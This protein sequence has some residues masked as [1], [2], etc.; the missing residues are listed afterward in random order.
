MGT[1]LRNPE[2]GKTLRIMLAVS[3]AAAVAAGFFSIPAGIITAAACLLLI[4]IYLHATRQRYERFAQLSY[5]MDQILHGKHDVHI[6]DYREGELSLI[7]DE[8]LKMTTALTEQ[9]ERLAEDKKYLSDSMADISHQLRTP[10]TSSQLIITLLRDPDISRARRRELLQELESLHAH[11]GWLVE[12]LLKISKMDAGTAYFKQD[13]IAVSEL[14]EEAAEP[15]LVPME[16]RNISFKT[17]ISKTAEFTGDLSWSKEAIANI[18][19]NCMEHVSDG[20]EIFIRSESNALY[21]EIQIEDSGRGF[22]P[23]DLPHIFERFYKGKNSSSG[24]VGIGL[25][26]ARMIVAEQNGTIKAENRTEG[27]ARF[28]IRFY[29]QATV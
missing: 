22:D 10:L 6:E 19:K 25:A 15:F 2:I 8:L 16:L 21:T 24:S 7:A 11:M 3:A 1:F 13:T 28:M 9:A 17:E 29:T 27:G 26:L 4:L 5:D 12:A 18:L 14:V 23:T 20:G